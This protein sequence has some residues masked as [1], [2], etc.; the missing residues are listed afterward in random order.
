MVNHLYGVALRVETV[1][2]ART[3]AVGTRR[4]DNIDAVLPQKDMPR[5]HVFNASQH[6]AN[7]VE[8]LLC[9]VGV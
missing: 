7:M 3:I 4:F 8:A 9:G 2:A 5:I 1:E 6:E